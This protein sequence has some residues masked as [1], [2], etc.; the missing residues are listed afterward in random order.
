MVFCVLGSILTKFAK[1]LERPALERILAKPTKAEKPKNN[2]F[3]TLN[4]I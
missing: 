1:A 2:L 3:R 4:F